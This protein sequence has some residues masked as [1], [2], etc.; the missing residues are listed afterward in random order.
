MVCLIFSSYP[1]RAVYHMLFGDVTYPCRD[2]FCRTVQRHL[3][4]A[5]STTTPST[6]LR[7]LYQASFHVS[8][9]SPNDLSLAASGPCSGRFSHTHPNPHLSMKVKWDDFTVADLERTARNDFQTA[10]NLVTGVSDRTFVPYHSNDKRFKNTRLLRISA[11]HVTH[12][13]L[14]AST[15]GRAISYHKD[16]GGC[17]HKAFLFKLSDV[18]VDDCIRP[19]YYVA[20]KK[21]PQ[22][23]LVKRYMEWHINLIVRIKFLL[24]GHVRPSKHR[25]TLTSSSASGELV[26]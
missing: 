13:V 10:F 2:C 9:L 6:E 26:F 12:R 17:E 8:L 24:A 5:C 21:H 1:V 3:L 7:T 22:E 18:V 19:I 14:Y 16:N 11:Q 20:P 15:N 4:F 23:T 25:R